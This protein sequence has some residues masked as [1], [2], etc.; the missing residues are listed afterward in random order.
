MNL[1]PRA[2]KLKQSLNKDTFKDLTLEILKRN[3]L[4]RFHGIE[5]EEFRKRAERL[6]ER[7]LNKL[8]DNL[9]KKQKIFSKK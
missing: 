1:S 5:Y 3:E 7:L 2:K 6:H 4:A 9:F 8:E